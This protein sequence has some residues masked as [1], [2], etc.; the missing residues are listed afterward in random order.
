MILRATAFVLIPLGLLLWFLSMGPF[1]GAIQTMVPVIG[2]MLVSR[3]LRY[4]TS[5]LGMLLIA[6]GVTLLATSFGRAYLQFFLSFASIT[7][8]P[9]A[10]TVFRAMW[11]A[12]AE[13]IEIG[14]ASVFTFLYWALAYGFCYGLVG[15]ILGLIICR[16][17]RAGK[18]V[19]RPPTPSSH[20]HEGG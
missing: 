13:M 20:E 11:I 1:L 6:C 9:V 16:L 15:G 8:V 2:P 10:F 5:A 18:P 17:W 4:A 19:S 12:S 7:G 3:F 14:E